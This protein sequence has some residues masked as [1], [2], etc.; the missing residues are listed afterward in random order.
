V[1]TINGAG[2]SFV[3]PLLSA[4]DANYTAGNPN[5]QINYQSVGSGAGI[6]DFSTKIVDFGATDAPLSGGPIGQRANITRDTGTLL[7][8]PESIGAVAIAYN[9][10]GISTTGLKLNATVAAMIFQGNITQWNDP[11]IANMNLGVN[12]PSSTIT[13]VH[14]SDSSGTTFIFSSWLNSSNSHF[15][16]KLG[17]SKTPKWQY[18]TKA[19]YLSLP[20]N[21]G[22]AGGVQQNPNTIG[23]VELNYVLSTTPPM[24]Y[25]TVLNGDQN[26]YVL[27]SLTTSTYAVNNSTA[28]LPTGDSDWSKVTLLNAHGGSSYPIVSFTYTLVFKELSVVPGM[29][30]AKAQ[31]FVNYLWFVVHSGQDQATKLS[32]VALP[33]PVRTIDEATIR[34]ITYNSVT[35]H[36]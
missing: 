11:I 33:S 25:A 34:M 8:I 24:T 6:T 26:G 19:T 29:T 36:G 23:Y 21:V 17:V 32:F 3:F 30:Q 28:S 10:N 5:V 31:A 35:L 12:L 4:I 14:R 1:I 22:V 7:T 16:W 9:V 2:S 20:Q 13:V 18:G 27:P 15:P